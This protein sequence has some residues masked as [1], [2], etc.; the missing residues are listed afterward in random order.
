M[1]MQIRLLLPIA[2][3]CIC[4]AAIAQESKS[5]SVQSVPANKSTPPVARAEASAVAVVVGSP[6]V[7]T[8]EYRPST[9]KAEAAACTKNLEQINAAIQSYRKENKDAPNWLSNLVPKY[10]ADT[11]VLICPVTARTG[12]QSAYGVLDPAI[13]CSYL[14]EFSPT[15]IPEV[16]KGAWPGPKMTMRQWKEQ[17][18]KLAGSG[19]PIVRCLLHEPSLNLSVGGKVYESPVFWE[20]N[21]TNA[22]TKLEDFSPHP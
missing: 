14:Y 19:V 5:E 15:E 4:F 13:R 7:N 20:M 2:F 9:D 3:G 18:M 11:N 22:T 8:N 6:T 21:F 12:L 16:V 10:L 1:K 17:Q